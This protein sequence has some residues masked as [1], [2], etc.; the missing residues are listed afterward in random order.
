MTD[1]QKEKI[2]KLRKEMDSKIKEVLTENQR[3]KLEEIEK[4]RSRGQENP[5]RRRGRRPADI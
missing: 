5:P 2:A 3:K 1:E 4:G